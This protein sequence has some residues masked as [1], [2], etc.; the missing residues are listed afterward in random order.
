MKKIV[1]ATGHKHAFHRVSAL[2]AIENGYFRD[3]GLGDVELIASGEDHLT[4]EGL[5]SGEIDYGADVKPGSVFEENA[6]GASIYI[7]GAMLDKFPSTLIGAPEIRSVAEM[8]WRG[9]P[10]TRIK[11]AS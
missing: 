8:S 1:L 4:V 2:A 3:E 11:S 10:S 7:I 6:Q 5:I 9:L